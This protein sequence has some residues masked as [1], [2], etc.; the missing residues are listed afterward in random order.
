MHYVRYECAN[1]A[2]YFN[3]MKSQNHSPAR[4]CKI[5]SC[6][7]RNCISVRLFFTRTRSLALT[8][9]QSS[10]LTNNLSCSLTPELFVLIHFVYNQS[11]LCMGKKKIRN[12]QFMSSEMMDFALRLVFLEIFTKKMILFTLF[13]SFEHNND[14][15]YMHRNA[16]YNYVY[17]R[18]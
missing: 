15:I 5:H 1:I 9:T 6:R 18:L 7:L 4:R 8:F 3:G 10:F 13:S 16:Q 14:N 17:E 2:I 12:P 11:R